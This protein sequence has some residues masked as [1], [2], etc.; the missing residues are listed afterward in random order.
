[1]EYSAECMSQECT[2]LWAKSLLIIS[3]KVMGFVLICFYLWILP[4]I[5]RCSQNT[6]HFS[7][8]QVQQCQLP[9]ACLSWSPITNWLWFELD[10]CFWLNH[11]FWDGTWDWKGKSSVKLCSR[12]NVRV[13]YLLRLNLGLDSETQ[14]T[15]NK[16]IYKLLESMAHMIYS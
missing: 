4:H 7:E 16:H 8:I 10:N 11:Y 3:L 13:F 15:Q 12:L 14:S 6:I 2:G 5:N 1:M 9:L